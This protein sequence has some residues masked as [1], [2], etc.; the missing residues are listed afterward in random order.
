MPHEE[1]RSGLVSRGTLQHER[2]ETHAHFSLFPPR[3]SA[4]KAV[5]GT[6]AEHGSY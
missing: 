6:R 1:K 3:Y 4:R 5:E 2:A